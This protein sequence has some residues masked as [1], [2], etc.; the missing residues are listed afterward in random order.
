MKI[1][2]RAINEYLDELADEQEELTELEDKES[3]QY[4]LELKREQENEWF[5]DW[6]YPYYDYDDNV[7]FIDYQ[8][9][10]L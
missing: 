7:D 9:A 8:D 3:E 2:D 5:Y 4:R 1:R 10:Y 6:K